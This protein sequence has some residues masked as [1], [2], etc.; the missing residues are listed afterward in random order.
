ME[1]LIP[2]DVRH[3]LIL[4]A[5][6][7]VEY[8][9]P[10]WKDLGP[11]ITKK[12][13][14]DFDNPYKKHI[15][16]WIDKVGEKKAYK[17]LDECIFKEAITNEHH[18]D[19][20]Y[21]ENSIFT[22]IKQIF[23]DSYHKAPN[24]WIRK[25]NEKI[26]DKGGLDKQIAFINYNYDQVLDENLLNYSHL[27]E[28]HSRFKY[29]PRLQSLSSIS[30]QTFCPH[31]TLFP[32]HELENHTYVRKSVKTMKTGDADFLD[33]V[34]CYDSDPHII[35]SY[36]Q[37]TRKL[38]ILGVGGGLK[39]NLDCIDF[40][41]PISEIHVTVKDKAMLNDVTSYLAQRFGKSTETI[42]VFDTC[43]DLIEKCF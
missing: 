1:F 6:A 7:S 37:S 30:I 20:V 25:L 11:Q 39:I 24:G 10:A 9:L 33:V 35:K 17:T 16:K 26:L 18:S 28:K 27:P 12:I 43:A 38:Y 13:I 4:G 40:E 31:G 14:S 21:V 42:K 36:R 19:G 8:G 5:G 22:I 34:S 41:I 2:N 15:S 23:I 29:K 32:E 3:I